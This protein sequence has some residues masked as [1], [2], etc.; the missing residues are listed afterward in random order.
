MG[1]VYFQIHI[2]K[3]DKNNFDGYTVR[4]LFNVY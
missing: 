2:D 3:L 4:G 1:F